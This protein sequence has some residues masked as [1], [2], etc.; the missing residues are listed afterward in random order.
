MYGCCLAVSDRRTSNRSNESLPSQTW[1]FPP[2]SRPLP[3]II[4]HR[5]DLSNAPENTLPAF[6]RAYESGADGI[7]LDVR[8]TRDDQLVVFHDRGLRRLGGVRGLVTNTTLKEMRS[9]D[10]GGW[11][12]PEFRGLQAPT[13]DEV[14]E[15]LPTDYLLNVEMKAVIDRMRLIAHK[16]AEVVRRHGRHDSTLVSSFNPISLWELRKIEPSILRGYIWSRR[17]PPPI[18]SRCFSRMVRAHWYDPAH[19]SY[20]PRLMRNMRRRNVKTLAWDVDFDRDLSRMASNRLDAVV[21]DDLSALL[22]QRQRLATI[23]LE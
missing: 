12:G 3:L 14:F 15:L 11:F 23:G 6:Q 19:D 9:L 22:K 2:G 7:E 20:N 18:R 17:H 4:A 1:E 5:G 10:V 16:V 13:L 21:T 8:L